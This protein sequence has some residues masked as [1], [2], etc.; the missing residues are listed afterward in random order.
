MPLSIVRALAVLARALPLALAVSMAQ[1]QSQQ[2]TTAAIFDSPTA[3]TLLEDARAQ[4]AANPSESARLVRRLLDDYGDRLVR[5]GGPADD[6]HRA[7]GLE[8]E[9][10][11]LA[12]PAVLARFRDLE[13]RSAERLLSE[14]GPGPTAVR[15]RLTKAGLTATIALAEQALRDGASEA[16]LDLLDRV[17]GHPDLVG[18]ELVAATALGG[19]ARRDLG[20]PADEARAALESLRGDP[21]LA[22]GRASIDAALAALDRT[23]RRGTA[24][25]AT[26]PLTGGSVRATPESAWQEIWSLELEESTFRRVFAGAAGLTNPR[27]VERARQD[28]N[29]MTAAPTVVGGTIF[30]HEGFRIRALDADSRNELWVRELGAAGVEREF[31]TIGDLAAAAYDRGALFL[32]EG[33]AFSN[34]RTGSGRIWSLDAA[35]GRTNWM[36]ASGKLEEGREELNGLFPVGV[37][38]VFGDTVVVLARKPTQRLEQVDWVVGLDR[39]TGSVRWAMSL[40]GTAGTRAIGGRR[41]AGVVRDG[42]YLVISTPLGVVARL[43]GSDGQMRWLRRFPV[44][45]RDLRFPSEPWEMGG[46]AAVGDRV[47]AIAPDEFEVVA[48]DRSSGAVVETR[49]IGPGTLWESPRYLL[50]SGLSDGS[51][52]VLG[53]G[54]DVVAFDPRDLSKRLWRLSDRLREAGIARPQSDNRSGIRGRVTIAGE[55]ALVPGVEDLL[56]VDLATGRVGARIEVGHP[57]NAVL[58]D[59]RIV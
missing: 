6:L 32:Y 56:V 21:S 37:P 12:N 44:P 25:L 49:A 47:I 8:A 52:I 35:T 16:A 33:H 34:A 41:H 24:S 5:V 26:S 30:L 31:G 9:D 58:L 53:V 15:R 4:A 3:Q 1:A 42:A 18:S 43:R 46:V 28:A 27:N 59:D 36:V 29:W 22:P 57:G 19:I 38:E 51:S 54:S 55:R 20:R 40:A 2:E 23:S 13:S 11:L 45:L 48:L 39:A 50:S 17:A 10:F 7:A 14:Q